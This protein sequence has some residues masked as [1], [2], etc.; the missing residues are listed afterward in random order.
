MS[1]SPSKR[2]A[3]VGDVPAGP[4]R[5]DFGAWSA[6]RYR[7]ADPETGATL[8][9]G[10][11]LPTEYL[12]VSFAAET[13]IAADCAVRV[14]PIRIFDPATFGERFDLVGH[15]GAPWFAG[16]DAD[17]SRL[18]TGA[19]DGTVR[20]WNAATGEPLKALEGHGVVAFCGEFSPDGRI[21]ATGGHDGQVRLWDTATWEELT[22]LHGHANYVKDVAW[23]RDGETLVSAS[24]DGTIRVWSPLSTSQRAAAGAERRR[25]AA[26]WQPRIRA[27]LGDADGDRLGAAASAAEA[28][29]RADTSL[30]GRERDVAL[31]VLLLECNERRSR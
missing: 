2:R 3:V 26:A 18:V 4:G 12:A 9:E 28:S 24:G 25:I 31:Q 14:G 17:G 29:I 6:R 27:M 13:A 7:I 16:S 23:S 5:E 19:A 8:V 10:P 15:T 1:L 30:S 20:I 11:E 22:S 21:L